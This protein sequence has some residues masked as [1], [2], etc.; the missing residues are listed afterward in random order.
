MLK[1]QGNKKTAAVPH[2]ILWAN[3]A[4][5]SLEEHGGR[6]VTGIFADSVPLEL[7][8]PVAKVVIKPGNGQFPMEQSFSQLQTSI[9]V[10]D[11][12]LERLIPVEY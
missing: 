4:N 12:P 3:R 5:V 1:N 9:F 2:G 7:D 8:Y 6:N 11:F 10:G